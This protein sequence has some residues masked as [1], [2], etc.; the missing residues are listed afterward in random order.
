MDS[1]TESRTHIRSKSHTPEPQIVGRFAF[2]PRR[3][4]LRFRLGLGLGSADPHFVQLQMA[5]FDGLRTAESLSQLQG[6]EE[7]SG[8]LQVTALEPLQEQ[9]QFSTSKKGGA[10]HWER[11][12]GR[13]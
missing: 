9:E 7:Q 2:D 11:R 6:Q 5:A 3:V 8:S 13:R 10:E 1:H 4:S 12:K